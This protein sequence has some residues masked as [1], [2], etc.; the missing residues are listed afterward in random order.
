ML[1]AETVCLTMSFPTLKNELSKFCCYN[2]IFSFYMCKQKYLLLSE[3]AR[4]I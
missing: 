2:S 1:D 4:C 3:E